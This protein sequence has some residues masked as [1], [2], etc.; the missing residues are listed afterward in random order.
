MES[1]K[2]LKPLIWRFHYLKLHFLFQ[3]LQLFL[4]VLQIDGKENT[5]QNQAQEK[6]LQRPEENQV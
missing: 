5:K 2:K 6:G 4:Q 3:F 1:K